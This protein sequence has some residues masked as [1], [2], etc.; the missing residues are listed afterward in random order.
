MKNIVLLVL[1]AFALWFFYGCKDV[2]VISVEEMALYS[3]AIV[4]I[5]GDKRTDVADVFYYGYDNN[6]D[7]MNDI[8]YL[9]RLVEYSERLVGDSTVL[10][11]AVDPW[12]YEI[13]YDRS[14]DGIFDWVVRSPNINNEHIL[15][16]L[17]LFVKP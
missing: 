9:H 3:Y 4:D 5:N 16:E 15:R 14:Y 12:V 17:L 10:D 1:I 11:F 2:N 7:G 6:E 13:W 8:A